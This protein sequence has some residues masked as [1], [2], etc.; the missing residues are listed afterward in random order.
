MA[1]LVQRINDLYA[2][3]SRE[4][5]LTGVHIGDYDDEVGG[6]KYVME[7]LIE[8]LLART[9]MPRFRLSSLEPVESL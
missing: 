4:V 3:G 7:D 2:E 1:D 8:N 6:K 9:K 5:V